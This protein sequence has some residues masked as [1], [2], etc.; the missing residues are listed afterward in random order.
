MAKLIT[1]SGRAS[2][3][4]WK[5]EVVRF[6]FGAN[7]PAQTVATWLE[8]IGACGNVRAVAGYERT[9]VVTLR[10]DVHM[11]YLE[12]LFRLAEGRE[13]LTRE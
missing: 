10:R 13:V 4:R 9:Y 12:T 11:G 2:R 7:A 3:K 8:S 6:T 5:R 1:E